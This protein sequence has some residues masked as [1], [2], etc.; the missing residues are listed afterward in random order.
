MGFG[1]DIIEKKKKLN[2]KQMPIWQM[3]KSDWTSSK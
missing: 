3:R 2:G 1:Q